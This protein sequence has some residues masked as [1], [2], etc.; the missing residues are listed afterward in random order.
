MR[1]KTVGVVIGVSLFGLAGCNLPF[2][3]NALQGDQSG[4][5]L[6]SQRR[7][8]P[9]APGIAP[10]NAPA[11]GTTGYNFAATCD[12]PNY[13]AGVS[14]PTEQPTLTVW[15]K[16]GNILINNATAEFALNPGNTETYTVVSGNARTTVIFRGDRTCNIEALSSDGTLIVSDNG[17]TR[18][19]NQPQPSPGPTITPTPSPTITPTITPTPP[20][21]P[22]TP[23]PTPT[24]L[25][26]GTF[27]CR[28]TIPNQVDFTAVYVTGQGFNRIDL[29]PLNS[30]TPI[31]VPL[32]YAGNNSQGQP[33]YRG[34]VNA[35]AEVTVT[36]QSS[37]QLR[38]G[39]R[40]QVQY[41]T[42]I[43]VGVCG[44]GGLPALW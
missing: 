32:F 12:L 3:Q 27:S 8:T 9:S 37:A 25:P 17:Q 18:F 16:P 42:G 36:Q 33:V 4:P 29:R 5:P 43:G 24:N 11:N 21:S 39:D 19:D 31:S 20:P 22:I 35:A 13:V 14:W 2:V 30:N 41:D 6:P 38:P 10:A 23:L 40:V 34:T 7:G 1:F 15:Q 28:G 26:G 44:G